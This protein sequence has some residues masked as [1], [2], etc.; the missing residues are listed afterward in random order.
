M[1]HQ[2]VSAARPND[3]GERALDYM[4]RKAEACLLMDAPPLKSPDADIGLSSAS[5]DELALIGGGAVPTTPLRRA[6]YRRSLWQSIRR[7]VP[8]QA[9]ALILLGFASLI[10]ITEDEFGCLVSNNLGG[11]DG[12]GFSSSL[13]GS[14]PP[15]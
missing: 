15:V 9:L 10:P 13:T 14:L 1:L 11:G 4:R 12:L 6:D 3:Y 7:S 8:V 2:R 5:G